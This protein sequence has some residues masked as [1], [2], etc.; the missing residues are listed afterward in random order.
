MVEGQL[1]V[2]AGK[3]ISEFTVREIAN[4]AYYLIASKFEPPASDDD[5]SVEEQIGIFEEK[6]WQRVPAEY[7][8]EK[9]MREKLAAMGIDPDAK[10]E[11]SPELQAKLDEDRER[12]NEELY[13]SGALDEGK[14]FRGKKIKPDEGFLWQVK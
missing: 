9:A 10:P 1:L 13:F 11:L 4:I 5:P 8:A 14:E 2:Q 6:I 7:K 3:G 12:T